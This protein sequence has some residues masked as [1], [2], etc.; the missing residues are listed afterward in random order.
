MRSWTRWAAVKLVLVVGGV[1]RVS[2]GGVVALRLFKSTG[3]PGH[4]R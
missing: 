2:T 3:Y 4:S 1:I